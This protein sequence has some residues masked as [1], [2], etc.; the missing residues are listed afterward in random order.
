M[1]SRHVLVD[2]GAWQTLAGEARRQRTTLMA[3]AGRL[4]AAEAVAIEAGDV[5]GSPSARRR[6]S[7][8]EGIPEPTDRVIR[9]VLGESARL[10]IAGYAA[11]R[12][13]SV[14]R[15]AGEVIEAAAYALGWRADRSL[16]PPWN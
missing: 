15:Y 3:L 2:P 14:A 6:R 4:L 8:G 5:R 10:T 13:E 1:I 9:V 11:E 16:A 7:P 12:D